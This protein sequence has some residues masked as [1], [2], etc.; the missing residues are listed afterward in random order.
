L[1]PLTENTDEEP[2]NLSRR[3]ATGFETCWLSGSQN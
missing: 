3:R 1:T 2:D